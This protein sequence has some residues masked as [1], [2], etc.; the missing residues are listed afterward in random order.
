MAELGAKSRQSGSTALNNDAIPP[1]RKLNTLVHYKRML[2]N[3]RINPCRFLGGK[4]N[5][6]RRKK[7]EEGSPPKLAGSPS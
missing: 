7:E 3:R 5:S 6:K 2:G 4:T 1:L